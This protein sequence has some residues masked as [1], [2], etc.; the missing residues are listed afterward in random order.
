MKNIKMT[1]NIKI[2]QNEVIDIDVPSTYNFISVTNPDKRISRLPIFY[3]DDIATLRFSGSEIG[4]YSIDFNSS[5]MEIEVEKNDKYSS[6]ITVNKQK[7]LLEKDGKPFYLFGYECNW[8]GMFTQREGNTKR[9]DNFIDLI[10]EH[11]F[12]TM[13][14]NVFAYDTTWCK[15]KVM[16]DDYGPSKL[17]PWKGSND[18]P[19]FSQFN[20]E[21]FKDFDDVIEALH[22]NQ[23]YSHLYFKVFNKEVNWPAKGSI[24]ES[25]FYDYIIK[26]YQSFSTVIWDFAKEAYYEGDLDYLENFYKNIDNLDS[27]HRLKT[28]HDNKIFY[29]DQNR[30]KVLDFC[31]TQQHYDIYTNAIWQREKYKMPIYSSEFG[32]EC[33]LEG[34]EDISYMYGQSPE[35]FVSRAW[36]I[37]FALSY[38]SYYYT[39]TA[40]D[41]IIPEHRP[42]GY[43]YWK[44]LKEYM[45]EVEYW[46]YSIHPELCWWRGR[47][48]KK[49]NNK[50]YLFLIE[51]NEH[52]LFNIAEPYE[53]LEIEWFDMFTAKKTTVTTNKKD[54]ETI[55]DFSQVVLDN[56]F[57][58][59][60]AVAKVTLK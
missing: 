51:E 16:E 9:L 57:K 10:K 23:I 50:E 41:I 18:N 7:Y 2:A 32:Y 40:W 20:E 55:E 39:Y 36:E 43:S 24:E 58:N 17:F 26:R 60:W 56:P 25:K 14:I 22:E 35:V 46:D 3:K 12:N 48:L 11:G 42:K 31:T 4:L 1:N 8:L 59:Q 47:C 38:P 30:I 21:Y 27:Y 54:L 19:D 6:A 52:A 13:N 49:N 53:S 33:G 5:K 37:A 34:S 45:E 28:L 29:E 44:Y 15:G